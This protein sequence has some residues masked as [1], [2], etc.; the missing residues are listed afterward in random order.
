[1]DEASM[2]KASRTKV[3]ASRREKIAA[4]RAAARRSDQRRRILIAGGSILA[5]IIVVVAFIVSQPRS[6]PLPPG[7]QT[8]TAD[9]QSIAILS[10]PGTVQ[11]SDLAG[12]QPIDAGGQ[13]VFPGRWV[14][15]SGWSKKDAI[16]KYTFALEKKKD[17]GNI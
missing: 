6:L 5:V 12:I 11:I 13:G 1:L 10:R 3:D 8:I 14:V 2:G 17:G 16:P 4:Q 7:F 9:D 15:V